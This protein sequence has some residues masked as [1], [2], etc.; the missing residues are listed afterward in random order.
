MRRLLE[1]ALQAYLAD[2]RRKIKTAFTI[3]ALFPDGWVY[4][5]TCA[6]WLEWNNIVYVPTA[7]LAIEGV[8][9][10]LTL[11]NDENNISLSGIPLTYKS[12]VLTQKYTGNPCIIRQGFF[13]FE[14]D[15]LIGN[16]LQI[17]KGNI[18]NMTF[19]D[20]PA[21]GTS[22]I[23]LPISSIFARFND[24]NSMKTNPSSH[25]RL[26]AN[27]TIFD[28]VPSLTDKVVEFGKL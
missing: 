14:T 27:D 11:A 26:F 24:K 23:V 1:P 25:K 19:T 8:S 15:Q 5:T 7:T 21:A 4:L 3:E 9:Q 13:D 18:N 28:Q 22:T 20:D 2:P 12:L 17:H 6:R 10:S 16:L